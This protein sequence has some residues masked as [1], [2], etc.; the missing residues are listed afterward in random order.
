MQPSTRGCP[1]GPG[2][3]DAKGNDAEAIE[4]LAASLKLV[5]LSWEWGYRGFFLM[6]ICS[7]KNRF[8]HYLRRFWRRDGVG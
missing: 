8:S 2:T 5:D 3:L 6:G 7:V 4:S 1:V